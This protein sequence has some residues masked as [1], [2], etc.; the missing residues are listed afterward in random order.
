MT[1]ALG[2]DNDETYANWERIQLPTG[3]W[4]LVPVQDEIKTKP[5]NNEEKQSHT[6]GSLLWL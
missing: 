3:M 4:I 6:T 2:Y 1:T 5:D